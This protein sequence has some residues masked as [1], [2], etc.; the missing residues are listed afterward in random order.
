MCHL[1]EQMARMSQ[2]QEETVRSNHRER[3]TWGMF[4]V[5][6]QKGPLQSPHWR[7]PETV[8]SEIA[9]S[10][11]EG[12]SRWCNQ[13]SKDPQHLYSE[14]MIFFWQLFRN[15][16]IFRTLNYSHTW[17]VS[18]HSAFHREGLPECLILLGFWI[19][20]SLFSPSSCGTVCHFWEHFF[21]KNCSNY[22][23]LN[24]HG[25]LQWLTISFLMVAAADTS[26]HLWNP[27][28]DGDSASLGQLVRML[29]SPY[30]E[31]IFLIYNLRLS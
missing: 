1:Y 19:E 15:K 11:A 16:Q 17:A 22:R 13:Y 14:N 7:D 3:T 20:K 2:G 27:S 8:P 6:E 12:A 18:S 9:V 10:V 30:S 26:A 25:I 24:T 5:S 28:R 31:K 29:N 23:I 4:L 21:L